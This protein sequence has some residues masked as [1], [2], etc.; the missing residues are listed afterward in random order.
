MPRDTKSSVLREL[1]QRARGDP[2]SGKETARIRPGNVPQ[3]NTTTSSGSADGTL[4]PTE[5]QKRYISAMLEDLDKFA[6][7]PRSGWLLL[8]T[9]VGRNDGTW[10]VI[11]DL[12][13]RNPGTAERK[14]LINKYVIFDERIL[15]RW[16]VTPAAVKAY[17]SNK[18]CGNRLPWRYNASGNMAHL[19]FDE[20][21]QTVKLKL[22]PRKEDRAAEGGHARLYA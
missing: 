16:D 12:F 3:N 21:R 11:C 2:L 14:I 6:S 20:S 13:I 4:V 15:K 22:R 19:V 5:H 18:W 9:K 10:K 17:C 7:T 8:E 1:R